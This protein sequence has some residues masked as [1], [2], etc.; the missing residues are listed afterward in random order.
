MLSAG[1][2]AGRLWWPWSWRVSYRIWWPDQLL[3][4]FSARRPRGWGHRQ[5]GGQ[6][7]P[8][9]GA[10]PAVPLRL[11]SLP[12]PRARVPGSWHPP[13]PSFTGTWAPC[14]GLSDL[15]RREFSAWP[16]L[17]GARHPHQA[18]R[19]G[20]FPRLWA[21][22]PA[23]ENWV[24]CVLL[25]FQH[26]YG[27]Q[28]TCWPVL[29]CPPGRPWPPRDKVLKAKGT[30]S[31][32]LQRM[33]QS[34]AALSRKARRLRSRCLQAML[35]VTSGK[36]SAAPSLHAHVWA[37]MLGHVSVCAQVCT[38]VCCHVCQCVSTCAGARLWVCAHVYV[39]THVP[40]YMCAACVLA[41]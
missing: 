33:F 38:C 30:A 28:G 37:C 12:W 31:A 7:Q 13:A 15:P 11:L 20:S 3:R 36:S 35:H 18:H 4:V 32:G 34:S 10:L 25:H 5:G 23:G 40:V 14:P 8:L 39:G 6:G 9:V 24:L 21:G 17:P 1:R 41:S 29:C 19:S 2:P 16:G 27:L 22:F 26:P